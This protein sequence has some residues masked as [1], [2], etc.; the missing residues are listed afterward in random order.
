[1]PGLGLAF[2]ALTRVLP[3]RRGVV[4]ERDGCLYVR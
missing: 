3:L 1:V 4:V 2:Q